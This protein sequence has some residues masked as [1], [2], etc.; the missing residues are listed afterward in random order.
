MWFLIWWI[1]TF[2]LTIVAIVLSCIM[3]HI[4]R[5]K[6]QR[7]PYEMFLLSLSVAEIILVPS[8]VSL[9][10][11]YSKTKVHT[12]LNTIVSSSLLNKL[13]SLH[14]LIVISADR[15]WAVVSPLTHRVHATGRKVKVAIIACWMIPLIIMGASMACL[16]ATNLDTLVK[17]LCALQAVGIVVADLIFIICY[18]T[19]MYIVYSKKS[20]GNLDHQLRVFRLCIGTVIIFVISSTPFVVVY[21]TEWNPPTWLI[22]LSNTMLPMNC[23]ATSLLFLHQNRHKRHRHN[24]IVATQSASDT[25]NTTKM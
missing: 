23:I 15:L 13:L 16:L 1:A 24:S 14:H 17:S 11:S 9:Y 2:V 7:K 12:I 6:K 19:I 21:I 10:A 3:I 25:V 20:L 5:K 4:L 18:G 22:L 8:Q